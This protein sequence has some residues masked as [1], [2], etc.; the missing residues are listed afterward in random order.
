[1]TLKDEIDLVNRM[2]REDRDNR[3]ID[4]ILLRNEIERIEDSWK[5]SPKKHNEK[6]PDVTRGHYLTAKTQM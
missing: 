2:I 5:S 1:M 4:F 6:A 3:V